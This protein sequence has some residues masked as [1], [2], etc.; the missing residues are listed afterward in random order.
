MFRRGQI[1]EVTFLDH[2]QGDAK[3]LAIVAFGRLLAIDKTSLTI[4]S[5]TYADRA[6]HED[7]TDGALTCFTIL[8]STVQSLRRLEP[9]PPKPTAS[10]TR[11]G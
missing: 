10:K 11:H 1:V 9:T 4:A 2:V 5:W 8:R 3:P 6:I 7:P